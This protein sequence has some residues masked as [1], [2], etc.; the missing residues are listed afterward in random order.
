M[1]RH[2]YFSSTIVKNSYRCFVD[3]VPRHAVD[4]R[5][6]PNDV[7]A[8]RLLA[9]IGQHQ[10]CIDASYHRLQSIEIDSKFI[11]E[12][13]QSKDDNERRTTEFCQKL[14]DLEIPLYIFQWTIL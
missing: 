7:E 14:T 11:Q 4:I 2:S 5:V 13:S 12:Y 8:D 10:N 3:T 6:L 1:K 9:K